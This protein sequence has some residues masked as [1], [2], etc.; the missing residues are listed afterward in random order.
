MKYL[1]ILTVLLLH[2]SPKEYSP[3]MLTGKGGL[4]FYGKGYQ[5]QKEAHKA[6]L[7]M[8]GAALDAGIAIE[9]VSSYRS[10]DRQKTI[11]T[12]KYNAFT[13]QGMTP[14][15][16]ITKIIEYSTIPGTSRHHWGTDMDIIQGGKS[17]PRAL[18]V[19]ENYEKGGVYA[20]MKE[21]MDMHA[22]SFGFYLVYT[23]EPKRCGF[24]YEPWHYTYKPLSKPMLNQFLA[25][26]ILS[27]LQKEKLA[28]YKAIEEEFIY[29]YINENIQEIN[30]ILME[31]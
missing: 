10:Y 29:K 13:A 2:S 12:R 14:K 15:E 26:D 8:K 9:I 17:K 22:N 5:L 19:E 23:K 24:K 18:L 27:M 11:W 21:W 16:A 31:E 7:R 1:I 20:K 3:E 6:F 25:L 28:G 4:Q 30:P